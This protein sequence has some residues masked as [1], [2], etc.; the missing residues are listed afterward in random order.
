MIKT[1]WTRSIQIQCPEQR[2]YNSDVQNA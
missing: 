1:S 2:P